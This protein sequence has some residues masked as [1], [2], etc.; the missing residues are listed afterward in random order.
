MPKLS[1]GEKMTP[2]V[3]LFC[4]HMIQYVCIYILNL[5]KNIFAVGKFK[6]KTKPSVLKLTNR[7][8]KKKKIHLQYK[9][10]NE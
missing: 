6:R 5:G 7:L 8:K 2:D 3:H 1:E 4:H 9:T 10:A